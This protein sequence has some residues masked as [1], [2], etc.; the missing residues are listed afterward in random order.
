MNTFAK[1]RFG[2]CCIFRKEPIKF[3]RT[4]AK[5]LQP[6]ARNQQL[7]HLSEIGRHNAEALQKALRYCRDNEVKGFRINSQIL[8]LK[9]HPAIGY[10]IKDLSAHAQIIQMFKH[11]GQFCR[12]HDMRTTFH[13]DQF[14]LLSSP[15][16]EVVRRSVADLIYQAV[17][18]QWVNADVI[19]IHG[20]GAYGD[21]TASL[22]RLRR[23]I[24]Q[25]PDPVRSRLTLENDDRIYTPKDLLPVCRDMGIPLVYDVHH[26]RCL[27]DGDSVEATTDLAL[28][29]WNR[30]PLFH[31]SSP[32]HGWESGDC[33][34]HHD[35]IDRADFPPYWQQLG[36]TVEVE[37]KA[38]EL[39]VLR[40]I[41]DLSLY[42]H[43]NAN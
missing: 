38:K 13:P 16:R 4:T 18:A 32:K 25:L 43:R 34:S 1:L 39:A 28:A 9:T 17:V 7:E 27:P 12:D 23:R 42:K 8:P 37:A 24:E 41:S 14:I 20:G 40:L 6:Y 3:R 5:Y 19:N 15:R 35:F 26:H 22:R 36:I 21:K 30:E 10:R 33:R 29:T 31:I 2:L 11:S